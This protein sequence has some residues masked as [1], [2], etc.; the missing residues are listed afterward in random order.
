MIRKN[1]INR[2]PIGLLSLF[3]AKVGGN[4]PQTIRED[5]Q[6]VID[7]SPFTQVGILKGASV[8]N[9]GNPPANVNVGVPAGQA[10][11]IHTISASV[12]T[13][14][15]PGAS[16]ESATAA[17]QIQGL[18]DD[19]DVETDLT[20]GICRMAAEG[21]TLAAGGSVFYTPGS[22]LILPSGTNMQ[23]QS[24]VDDMAQ[25]YSFELAVI[26]AELVI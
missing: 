10:W 14:T 19:D 17:L 5:V 26:Y 2:E 4:A 3:R 22:P 25:N 23:V 13:N 15:L 20:L 11:L 7:V 12:Y 21:Q 18:V 8:T 16:G 1:Q 24:L 9:T 6:A